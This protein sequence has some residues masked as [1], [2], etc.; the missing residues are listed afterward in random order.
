LTVAGWAC[1]SVLAHRFF[2]STCLSV[3]VVQVSFFL[4]NQSEEMEE[5]DKNVLLSALINETIIYISQRKIYMQ[6]FNYQLQT[7]Y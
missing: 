1:F 5:K 2:N 4:V 3:E 7:N 6:F